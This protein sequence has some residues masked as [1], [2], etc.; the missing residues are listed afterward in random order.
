MVKWTAKQD[1]FGQAMWDHAHGTTAWEVVER[2]D[3][4]V[5][6]SLGPAAYLAEF[7]DW[8]AH[9][10]NAIVLARGRVLDV[11]CGAGRVALHLQ[12]KGLDVTGV[13]VSPLAIKVCRKRGL[14]KARAMSITQLSARMGLFDTIVMYGNNFGLFGSFRRARWLLRRLR[15][16]TSPGAGIIAESRDPYATAVPEHLAYHR[17]NRRRGRMAGQL[18]IRIRYKTYATPFYDCLLVSKREMRQIVAGT[19]WRIARTF[20]APGSIYVAVLEKAPRG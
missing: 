14:K 17:R 20:D 2:D 8:P 16:M 11:G 3:G 1:A 5:G 10:R 9:Q 7:K 12:K 13:D 19:G 6:L 15:H 18:R 4:F